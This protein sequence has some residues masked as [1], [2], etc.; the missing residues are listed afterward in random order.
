MSLGTAIARAALSRPPQH[1]YGPHR[2]QV[3]D[4]H[5]PRGEGPFPVAVVIHGGHWRTT[6]GKLVTRPIAR[7]LARRGIAA[8]NLEYRRL[9]E[10]GGWPATF[11]DV[12]R[13]IGMLDELG[14]PRLD[15]S[16]LAAV[17]HSAGGQLALWAAGRRDT[18]IER[19]VALA[20]VTNLAAAGAVA[21]ELL[22]GTPEQVPERYEEADPIRRA[23]LSTPVLI[24]HASDDATVPIRRSREYLAASG[25][26]VALH[27]T[28]HGGHRAPIFPP[29]DAWQTAAGWLSETL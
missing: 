1:R 21:H 24:V 28:D 10:G 7:D 19:V 14:D 4:L 15:H 8:L 22:G 13:G 17:G 11:D 16:R 20:P 18:G 12:A 2:S 23:P 29:T 5:V 9:G 25:D 26:A 3:A 6:W 27:A